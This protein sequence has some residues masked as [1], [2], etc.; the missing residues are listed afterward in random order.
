[1]NYG[2]GGGLR[3]PDW[4]VGYSKLWPMGG[5]GTSTSDGPD[6]P[7]SRDVF[8]IREAE[9]LFITIYRL[10]WVTYTGNSTTVTF[11]DNEVVDHIQLEKF[12]DGWLY[13]DI[14]SEE[15]LLTIDL[16]NPIPPEEFEIVPEFSPFVIFP[17]ILVFSITILI[18]KKKMKKKE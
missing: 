12:A 6:D 1:M 2:G 13:N 7:N 4:I 18:A 3:K 15:E 9:K 16:L 14:I 5:A 8:A 11:L 17:I 10:G